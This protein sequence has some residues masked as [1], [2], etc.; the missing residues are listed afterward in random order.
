MASASDSAWLN[1]AVIR[2][3]QGPLYSTPLMSFIDNK[4][5]IFDTEEEC[6]LEY[7]NVHEE[8]KNVRVARRAVRRARAARRNGRSRRGTGALWQARAPPAPSIA[9]LFGLCARR[10][11]PNR[12]ARLL[13][14][15]PSSLTQC[16]DEVISDF[17]NDLGVSAEQFAEV[18]ESSDSELDAFVVS[19]ILTVDDFVQFRAMMIKRN[20]DLTNEVLR[21]IEAAASAAPAELSSPVTTTSPKGKEAAPEPATP[22]KDAEGQAVEIVKEAPRTPKEAAEEMDEERMME[23]AL[24]LSQRQFE[25]EKELREAQEKAVANMNDGVGDDASVEDKALAAA[26][27]ESMQEQLEQERAKAEMQQALALSAAI[28]EERQKMK[29]ESDGAR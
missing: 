4:C 10:C 8:F 1:E 5:H 23:M 11:S 6:K 2:F 16:V 3:L 7:T 21:E 15:T 12:R 28:E 19:S 13:A 18:V 17:L 14:L 26:I 27:R 24:K 22:T 29:E 25:A 20:I 9:P